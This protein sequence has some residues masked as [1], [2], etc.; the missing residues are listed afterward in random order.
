MNSALQIATAPRALPSPH[1]PL[2]YAADWISTDVF[3]ALEKRGLL[4]ADE[5]K[6]TELFLIFLHVYGEAIQHC[7]RTVADGLKAWLADREQLEAK[8][9][10][11]PWEVHAGYLV[12][13]PFQEQS[14]IVEAH[15]PY[16]AENVA[17]IAALHADAPLL[18]AVVRA[19]AT[20]THFAE[21]MGGWHVFDDAVPPRCSLC[22]TLAD[23]TATEREPK[24]IAGVYEPFVDEH[25]GET[26]YR[27]KKPATQEGK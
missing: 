2:A 7:E 15:E 6:R 20:V 26:L 25:T 17:L 13:A 5:G 10:P 4:P 12:E 19:A 14:T 9:T 18:R 23:L 8:A 22:R 27:V 16:C 3:D 24:L 11:G 21:A 1:A